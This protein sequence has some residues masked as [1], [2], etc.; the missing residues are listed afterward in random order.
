M[1]RKSNQPGSLDL[2][3]DIM[4]NTDAPDAIDME[5]LV[6]RMATEQDLIVENFKEVVG[7]VLETLEKNNGIILIGELI[8]RWRNLQNVSSFDIDVISYIN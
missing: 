6:N 8:S 4:H 1:C 2:L 5:R 7:E 3:V